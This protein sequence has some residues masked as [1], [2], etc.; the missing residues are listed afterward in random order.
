MNAIRRSEVSKRY[1]V[2]D[3]SIIYFDDKTKVVNPFFVNIWNETLKDIPITLIIPE[4]VKG[5]ICYQQ[6]K[7]A[8]NSHKEINKNSEL[9]SKISDHVYKCKIVPDKVTQ[10][11]IERF[12]KWCKSFSAEVVKTPIDNIDWEKI[13]YNSLWREPP[14]SKEGDKEKG[15]RDSIILETLLDY[16]NSNPR[17]HIVFICKDRLLRDTAEEILKDN[18]YVSCFAKIDE[19]KSNISLLKEKLTLSFVE[20]ITRKARTKF[21]ELKSDKSF[22][23]SANIRN[24]IEIKFAK[25]LDNPKEERTRLSDLLGSSEPKK[26]E[27]KTI[28][29]MYIDNPEFVDLEK[30]DEYHWK[31]KIEVV[32]DFIEFKKDESALG[33]MIPLAIGIDPA[34]IYIRIVEV[35]I[36]WKVNISQNGAFRNMQ[37]LNIMLLNAS[38][39]KKTKEDEENYYK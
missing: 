24:L 5:E 22:F 35:E 29:Y 4:V 7:Q 38:F 9:L 2:V 26:W 39:R 6:N 32:A 8:L 25:E 11:V 23:Y 37:V 10:Q 12:D 30:T 28:N 21:F 20:L 34:E 14:F 31:T 3:S 19:F 1:V 33:S 18:K 27:R 16:V 13:I 36:L 17:R 15:F